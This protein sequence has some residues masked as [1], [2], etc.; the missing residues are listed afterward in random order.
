M[1][2]VFVVLLPI[3]FLVLGAGFLVVSQ[4][5][6]FF[7]SGRYSQKQRVSNQMISQFVEQIALAQTQLSRRARQLEELSGRLELS[8]QE[9]ARLS[10][11]KSKFLSMAVHDMRTPLATIQG[12]SQLLAVKADKKQAE[13]LQHI[14]NA[15]TRMNLLMTDLT[16]LAMIEAGKL[17]MSLA[18]FDFA[19]MAREMAPGLVL[20]AQ[21]KGVELQVLEMPEGLPVVGDRFRL[22]QV[23]QNLLNNAVK[24]TPAGGKVWLRVRQEGDKVSVQVR[25]SGPGIHPSE[26]KAIFEKFYQSVFQKDAKVKGAGWGLGLSI[27]SEIIRAHRGVIGVESPGLGK[28]S[29]FYFKVPVTQPSVRAAAKP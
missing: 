6:G 26:R 22:S 19:Q 13:Y 24:F 27:A 17:K 4:V 23:L 15:G 10:N 11:M 5:T 12:F 3:A 1:E 20:I 28:G 21:K 18:P 14:Y 29:T 8:N 2:F 7:Q 9:L 25:D 16:D